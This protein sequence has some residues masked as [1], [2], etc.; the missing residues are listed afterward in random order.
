M[1][2]ES[3]RNDLIEAFARFD[4]DNN[5]RIDRAEFEKLLDALGSTMSSRD[6]DLGF[7]MVDADGDGSITLEEMAS[8]WEVVRR[9]G[10]GEG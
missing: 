1:A 5:Y 4:T 9:E 6:R 3:W 8:W 7:A 2:T 10:E